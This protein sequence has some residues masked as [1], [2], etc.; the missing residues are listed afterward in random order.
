MTAILPNYVHIT[1]LITTLLTIWFFHKATNSTLVTLIIFAW[2]VV[3]TI[4]AYLG[5]YA[6]TTSVPP[7]SML[8]IV[9][10]IIAIL[11]LFITQ[12]GR[13]LI[14]NFNDKWLTYL[15]V[16]RIPVEIVLLWLSIYKLVPVAMTFEGRNFD[17]LSGLTAPV[18]AYLGYKKKKLSKGFIIIWN[19]ICIGLV[20]NVAATGVLSLPTPFQ[21]LSFDQPN[22][23]V[24]QFPFIFLPCFIVPVVMLSH[25]ICIRKA[26]RDR[27]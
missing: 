19:I 16:V 9:P 26:L 17:I 23:G 10:W 27:N 2:L 4:I 18:V 25:F 20:V 6:D 5:F 3:Q 14:D 12:R 22:V 24:L 7:H 8:L 13:K 1:F 21:K 11:T 15:H